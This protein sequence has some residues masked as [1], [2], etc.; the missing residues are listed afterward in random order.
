M[1]SIIQAPARLKPE[2]L[3][4]LKK[5]KQLKALLMAHFGI[6]QSTLNLWIQKNST[7]FT[8]FSS[9]EIL[10]NYFDCNSLEDMLNI[11]QKKGELME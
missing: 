11:N 4:R 5:S 1:A 7:H 8:Q 6:S 9:L 2:Y 10:M 3:I